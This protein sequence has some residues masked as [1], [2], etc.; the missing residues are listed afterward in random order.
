MKYLKYTG[1]IF[2]LFFFIACERNKNPFVPLIPEA[3]PAIKLTID[4]IPAL[5][6]STAFH[7]DPK[8][9]LW[10]AGMEDEDIYYV[11]KF[12]YEWKVSQDDFVIMDLTVTESRETAQKYLLERR[13]LSSLPIDLQLSQDQ[14]AV[15]GQISY[16]NGRDFIRDNLLI[17]IRAEGQFA[18][19]VP[20]IARQIDALILQN[21]KL[22]FAENMRPVIHKFEFSDEP[23]HYHPILE[24]QKKIKL[25]IDVS[26][27]MGG[28][29]YYDWRFTVTSGYY[30]GIVIDEQGNYYYSFSYPEPDGISKLTIIVINDS[31]FLST[32]S[33]DFSS[34]SLE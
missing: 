22:M 11:I 9:R 4:S 34:L 15:A 10:Q 8:P 1:P 23:I 21:T 2:L 27:P 31:G 17:E 25:I 26:D 16:G 14:P 3:R 29:L 18:E 28:K 30:G 20:E 24:P 12:T 19:K 7:S 33:V 6:G 5:E 32:A 13:L